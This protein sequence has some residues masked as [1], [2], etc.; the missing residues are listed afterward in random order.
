MAEAYRVVFLGRADSAPP[1]EVRERIGQL[2][3]LSA[4]QVEQ[5]FVR[6][7]VAV[8]KNLSRALADKLVAALE[9]CGA[10][11]R[12]EAMPEA[13]P[14]ARPDDA[15]LSLQG[16][17]PQA[18]ATMLCPACGQEQPAA[19]TCLFCGRVV[20]K[21][22]EAIRREQEGEAGG[23]PHS[24][25]PEL[26]LRPMSVGEIMVESFGMLRERLAMFAGITVLLPALMSL[27][28]IAAFGALAWAVLASHEVDLQMLVA[29]ALTRQD[30]G[31]PILPFVVMCLAAVSLISF[32]MLWE[33][34]S[35][36]YA[37]SERHLGRDTGVL[38][39][40]RFALSRMGPLSWTSLTTGLLVVLVLIGLMIPGTIMG[41]LGIA[42]ALIAA[43][44]FALR[45]I[46]VEKVVVLEGLSGGEARSRSHEL[47]MANVLR[48]IG[49][50][51]LLMLIVALVKLSLNVFTP[52]LESLP[53]PLQ[54]T[55][56]LAVAVLSGTFGS[57]FPS[58]GLCL[59]YYDA[60]LRHDGSLTSEDLARN[61]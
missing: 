5:L 3:K 48:L 41:P 25:L 52:L 23:G 35:L 53:L 13:M 30:L 8:K 29:A 7:P 43:V 47:V 20:A 28:V 51:A 56:K 9:G 31:V 45:Y 12:L 6:A 4:E 26:N 38:A 46:L 58:M 14:E 33:Q 37:V 42:A 10:R 19:D 24:H 11:A 17:A 34:A 57:A 2:F 60:R 27:A 59:F 18:G 22:Q 40:Y 55:G 21:V 44:C 32:I 36:T 49:M 54:M 15:P 61:L 50:V 1:A 16:A 39:A